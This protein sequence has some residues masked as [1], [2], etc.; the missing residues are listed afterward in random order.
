MYNCWN[1]KGE[2]TIKTKVPASGDLN[3]SVDLFKP[4]DSSWDN[5]MW[6]KL[7]TI[8]PCNS[9]TNAF[10]QKHLLTTFASG[11]FNI[12]DWLEI[13]NKQFANKDKAVDKDTSAESGLTHPLVNA[14]WNDTSRTYSP[15]TW[16]C[17]DSSKIN[18]EPDQVNNWTTKANEGHKIP[19]FEELTAKNSTDSSRVGDI[20]TEKLGVDKIK[21]DTAAKTK[22]GR[23]R[24]RHDVV[25]KSILRAVKNHYVDDFKAFYN[26][27]EKAK[28]TKQGYDGEVYQ[29]AREYIRL[30]LPHC[31]YEDAFIFFVALVDTKKQ[32]V[33]PHPK[34]PQICKKIRDLLH[35]YN[36]QRAEEM[37]KFPEFAFLV[38][39]YLNS[40]SFSDK[41]PLY[42]SKVRMFREKWVDTFNGAN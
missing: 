14:H 35:C 26:F 32:Y 31:T 37:L 34:Y 25:E 22:P 12:S 8:E 28:R 7:S 33:K 16:I 11:G 42:Q 40:Q 6:Q 23:Y 36:S 9:P 39:T 19:V 3:Q 1:L 30:K 5:I 15:F 2:L 13:L 18:A 29:N 24:I 10:N 38:R 17:G 21:P 20:P 41:T 27:T 4:L